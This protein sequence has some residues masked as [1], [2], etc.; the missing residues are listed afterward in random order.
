MNFKEAEAICRE[1]AVEKK[2]MAGVYRAKRPAYFVAEF[3]LGRGHPVK[4]VV[5]TKA[6]MFEAPGGQERLRGLLEQVTQ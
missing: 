6:D 2:L 3:T 4:Q 5:L 1:F